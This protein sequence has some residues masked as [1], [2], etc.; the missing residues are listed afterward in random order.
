MYKV[1]L[2][3]KAQKRLSKI[4]SPYYEKIKSAILELAKNPIP[5]G[6]IKLTGRPAYRIRIADYRVIYEIHKD[7]LIVKVI[8]VGHRKEIY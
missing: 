4:P 6:H 5:F 7:K 1:L 2:E 8:D 3:R